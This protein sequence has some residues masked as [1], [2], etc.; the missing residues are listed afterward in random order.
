MKSEFAKHSE[1]REPF[2]SLYCGK[3]LPSRAW[4]FLRDW[5]RL[6]NEW[7]Q[8]N[9]RVLL[10]R[11]A[12]AD[13]VGEWAQSGGKS[14]ESSRLWWGARLSEAE[15]LRDAGLIALT[16]AER[17]DGALPSTMVPGSAVPFISM[18]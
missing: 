7:V 6:R 5:S 8:P 9:R 11:T 16:Q 13:A 1:P 12:L 17:W 3:P 2:C 4:E 10:L 15:R 14:D 18:K